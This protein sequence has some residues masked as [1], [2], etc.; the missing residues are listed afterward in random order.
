MAISIAK[1]KSIKA[2]QGWLN[3]IGI[4]LVIFGGLLFLPGSV[5]IGY[6]HMKA[7]G[8]ALVLCICLVSIGCAVMKNRPAADTGE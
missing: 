1:L 8:I 2:E 6:F 5:I 7:A 4:A 3:L